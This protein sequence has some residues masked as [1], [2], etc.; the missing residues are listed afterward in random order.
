MAV[1]IKGQAAC[2]ALAAHQ[3]APA[4]FIDLVSTGGGNVTLYGKM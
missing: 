1:Q 3:N 2:E 4:T